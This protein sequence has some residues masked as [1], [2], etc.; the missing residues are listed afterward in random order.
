M[1]TCVEIAEMIV[2]FGLPVICRIG[3]MRYFTI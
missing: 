1:L 2:G 3:E